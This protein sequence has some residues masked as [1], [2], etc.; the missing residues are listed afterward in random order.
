MSSHN[1]DIFVC[2]LRFAPPTIA[3]AAPRNFNVA[4][5]RPVFGA[6]GAPDNAISR[7]G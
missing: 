4:S 3:A 1:M 5:R 7:A 2:R 6:A